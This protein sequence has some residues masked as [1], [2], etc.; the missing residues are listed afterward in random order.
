MRLSN[1]RLLKQS[2]S[3][4][5]AVRILD[6]V[7][8]VLDWVCIVFGI[9][10]AIVA[11]QAVITVA[12]LVG[13]YIACRT[14]LALYA[15]WLGLRLIHRWEG[16]DWRAEYNRRRKSDSLA[17]EAVLH[18]VLLPNYNEE[19]IVLRQT[20]DKLALSPLAK[21]QVAVVLAMEA[22]ESGAA[23]KAAILQAEYAPKFWRVLATFHPIDLPGETKVKSA[24]EAWASREVKRILAEDKERNFVFDHVIVTASD[25]DT[26]L[27]PQYLNCLTCMF[28]TNSDRHRRIWQ[29]PVYYHNNVWDS[30]PAFGMV[31]AYSAAWE[32]AFV[33][34]RW[35]RTLPIS[36]YS[37]SLRLI[38]SVGYWD[39]NVIP[40]ESHMY[41]KCFYHNAGHLTVERV[42][43]PF[44]SHAVAGDSFWDSC[45]NRYSQTLR[46]GWGATDITYA[47]L[48]A[49]AHPEVPVPQAVSVSLRIAHDHITAGAG[50]ILLTLGAQLPVVLHPSLLSEMWHF[51]PFIVLQIALAIIAVATL[52][53]WII[54]MRRRPS[55]PRPWT[56]RE[57]LTTAFSF[58]LLPVLTVIFLGLPVIEA[59][60]R[61]L[62]GIPLGF[63]VARKV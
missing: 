49:V 16:L 58:V 31:Y 52:T 28:A 54:D 44:S 9:I 33:A 19:L 53:F 32:L 45:K 25:A 60:T 23:A 1:A 56:S 12:A 13:A 15:N 26:Q 38:D 50:W 10:G 30:H 11:P 46:H 59:Q 20:L 41:L 24:N 36:T 42:F 61:M 63:K 21:T 29:A 27:H 22:R 18:V 62:L 34:G 5:P 40:D 3:I 43:L 8:G 37:L 48:Q 47:I 51:W 39:T 4:A 7:L 35:W 55:R 6:S 2:T 17:W 14:L 57:V